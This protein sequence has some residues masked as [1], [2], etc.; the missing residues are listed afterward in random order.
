MNE[1]VNKIS[2]SIDISEKIIK[3]NISTKVFK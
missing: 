3:S 2:M 1:N